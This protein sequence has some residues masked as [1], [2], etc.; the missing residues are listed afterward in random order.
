[1]VLG[2]PFLSLWKAVTT[3]GTYITDILLYEPFFT[4]KL[5]PLT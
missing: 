2:V 4:V 1:M 5:I 3:Y